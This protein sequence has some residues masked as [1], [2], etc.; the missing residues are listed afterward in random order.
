[1]QMNSEISRT[2]DLLSQPLVR[3]RIPWRAKDSPN[4]SFP[5]PLSDDR[6]IRTRFRPFLGDLG[7]PINRINSLVLSRHR[8]TL[9]ILREYAP[10]TRNPRFCAKFDEECRSRLTSGTTSIM[11]D[12]FTIDTSHR[13]F[14]VWF[15]QTSQQFNFFPWSLSASCHATPA[16]ARERSH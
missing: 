12:V 2:F 3:S 9:K 7:S 8:H 4:S 11:Y 15:S 6:R 5:R 16:F 13:G 10:S 14:K 1:M